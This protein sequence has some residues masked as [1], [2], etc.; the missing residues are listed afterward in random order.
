MTTTHHPHRGGRAA[1]A[2]I[3]LTTVAMAPQEPSDPSLL[4]LE[5]IFEA[6]EF[7]PEPQPSGRWLADGSGYVR[8]EERNGGDA[9]VA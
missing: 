4:T 8:V 6:R 3:A 7:A 1:L 5:R 9:I 2:L